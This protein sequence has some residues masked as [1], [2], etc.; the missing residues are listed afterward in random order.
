VQSLLDPRTA[1]ARARAAVAYAGLEHE[2]LAAKT[3]LSVPMLRRI[4][5]K[6]SPRDHT[7]DRLWMIAD[8][9]NV[10]RRFMEQGWGYANSPD[11][12][13][14]ERRVESNATHTAALA[15]QVA[16]LVEGVDRL[17]AQME[18]TREIVNRLERREVGRAQ[19]E[20][21]RSRDAAGQR[22]TELTDTPPSDPRSSS[23]P[24]RG[25]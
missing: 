19:A 13:T 9:C 15:T 8:A 3:G 23:D 4:M 5:S 10:D 18:E 17:T 11:R 14:I 7:M 25:S 24:G 22:A 6:T 1:A 16:T 2:E 12:S 20:I 21:L